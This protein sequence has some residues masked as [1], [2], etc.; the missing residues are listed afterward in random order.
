MQC[1]ICKCLLKKEKDNL[2]NNIIIC[3]NKHTYDVSK[4]GYVNLSFKSNSGDNKE[5]VKNR[6]SFLNK[7]YYLTLANRIKE[8]VISLKSK[9]ILDIGCGEGY[10]DRIIKSDDINITGIDISKDAIL[11]ACKSN[12]LKIDY[13][14]ASAFKIP[15]IDDYFDLILSIFAPIDC[16]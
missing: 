11:Y 3:E 5:M 8:I 12:H 14:V 16:K 1:P 13:V 9:N 6:H 10:F 15:Y 4:Y 2:G 7:D